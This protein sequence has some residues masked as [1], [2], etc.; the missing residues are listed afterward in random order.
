VISISRL[1]V[2]SFTLSFL[3]IYWQIA[4]TDE[5][6]SLYSFRVKRSESPEGP[7][8]YVSAPLSEVFFFRDDS[9]NLFSIWRIFYYQVEIKLIS[10][11]DIGES[12]V[13][14]LG[15]KPDLEAMEISRLYQ[16][17]LQS[18]IGL[19]MLIIKRRTTGPSCPFCYDSVRKRSTDSD[20]TVCL[21]TSQYRGGY[22]DPI[23]T[24]IN[25]SPSTKVLRMSNISETEPSEKAFDMAGYPLVQVG[26]TLIHPENRRYRVTQVRHR[27]KRGFVHRQVLQATEIPRGDVIYKLPID[28]SKFPS[29]EGELWPKPAQFGPL[30]PNIRRL[31]DD[32]FFA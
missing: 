27:S 6:I 29:N 25:E 21:G 9:V 16:V 18:S 26:D 11:G 30:K 13:A 10:S 31:P 14:Y 23:G 19:P 4:D 3:D 22:L 2:K 24:F 28:I 8:E 17:L 1:E 12:T 20:C 5:D 15:L 7:F 32:S